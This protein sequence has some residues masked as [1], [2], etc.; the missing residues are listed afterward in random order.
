MFKLDNNI[1]NIDTFGKN[2]KVY[3]KV[4]FINYIINLPE[5]QLYLL[6]SR[7]LFKHHVFCDTEARGRKD[8]VTHYPFRVFIAHFF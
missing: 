5:V 4:G 6:Y 2:S 3:F 1:C 7:C 8:A